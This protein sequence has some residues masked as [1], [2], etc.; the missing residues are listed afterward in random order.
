MSVHDLLLAL[1]LPSADDAA[2]DLACIVGH[3][4]VARFVAMM[5]VRARELGLTDT[6]YSTPIGFDT[7]GNYSSASDLVK[8]ARYALVARTFLSARGGATERHT[9]DRELGPP[10]HQPQHPCRPGAVDQ[11]RQDG[12]HARRRLC[13]GGVR[14]AGGTDADQRRTRDLQRVESRIPTRS[15]CS[16]TDSPP[17]DSCTRFGPGRL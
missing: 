13:A 1:L 11:R 6:H 9:A 16:T 8:L 4:S 10:C 2:E 17:S 3:G 7:P 15:R 12:P 14:N 5:N